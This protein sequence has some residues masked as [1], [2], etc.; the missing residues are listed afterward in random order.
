MRFKPMSAGLTS[1]SRLTSSTI[2]A[3]CC[4]TSNGAFDMA[5]MLFV[6][7]LWM[8]R[9]KLIGRL[10]RWQKNV[11]D[12]QKVNLRLSDKRRKNIFPFLSCSGQRKRKLCWK[13]RRK[14]LCLLS[15]PNENDYSGS[16]FVTF[17]S[18]KRISHRWN[19]ETFFLL[20]LLFWN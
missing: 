13:L 16:I 18:S 11:D 10:C 12:P 19:K 9:Q 8:S 2:P 20:L 1:P 5:R 17:S 7:T 15:Q 3:H 14:T 6:K 4:L